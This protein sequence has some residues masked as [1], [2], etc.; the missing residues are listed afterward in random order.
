MKDHTTAAAFDTHRADIERQLD[1]ILADRTGA[2]GRRAVLIEVYHHDTGQRLADLVRCTH[3]PVVVTYRLAEDRIT[4][5][6]A[7]VDPL[8]ADDDQLFP[9]AASSLT[10]GRLRVL[11]AAGKRRATV[12]LDADAWA[13]RQLAGYR[14]GASALA[15]SVSLRNRL[16]EA[17]R[18]KRLHGFSQSSI[19][20]TEARLEAA[21]AD[22]AQAVAQAEAARLQR[23]RRRTRPR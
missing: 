16:R 8:T 14:S 9:L 15:R 4:G 20:D 12:T 17:L 10:A 21:E 5:E 22:Y 11:L 1:V 3:G 7:A 18:L 13:D 19:G 23:L 6:R 2:L